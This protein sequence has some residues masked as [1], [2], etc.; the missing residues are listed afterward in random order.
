MEPNALT[1]LLRVNLS[2]VAVYILQA[3]K[4]EHFHFEE[5]RA[6]MLVPFAPRAMQ[7]E[8]ENMI[9]N[10]VEKQNNADKERGQ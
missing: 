3:I 4:I 5:K 8:F 7:D 6:R 2:T 10:R 1:A 9:S